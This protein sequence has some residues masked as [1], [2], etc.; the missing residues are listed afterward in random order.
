MAPYSSLLRNL[1]PALNQRINRK[2]CRFQI[3]STKSPEVPDPGQHIER[4]VIALCGGADDGN[5]ILYDI[6]AAG[7]LTDETYVSQRCTIYWIDFKIIHVLS[8][9]NTISNLPPLQLDNMPP[10]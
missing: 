9:Q 5:D 1:I 10:G 8:E 6:R 4:F 3:W 2:D 7:P